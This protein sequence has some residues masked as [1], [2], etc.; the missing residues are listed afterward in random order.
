V[1]GPGLAADRHVEWH[2]AAERRAGE[3]EAAHSGNLRAT[4]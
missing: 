1:T 2:A 4:T 3:G